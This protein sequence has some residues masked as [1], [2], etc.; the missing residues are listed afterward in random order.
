MT[1]GNWGAG[2]RI[3]RNCLSASEEENLDQQVSA[4]RI[5]EFH[6][7]QNRHDFEMVRI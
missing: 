1:A 2:V 4:L 3:S 6:I 7:K 5:S